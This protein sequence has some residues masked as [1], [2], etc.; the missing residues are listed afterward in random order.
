MAFYTFN[1][2]GMSSGVELFRFRYF[3]KKLVLTTFTVLALSGCQTFDDVTYKYGNGIKSVIN[4]VSSAIACIGSGSL[5]CGIGAGV[6]GYINGKQEARDKIV[7]KADA[8]LI[9]KLAEVKAKEQGAM[10]NCSWYQFC[11]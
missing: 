3:M 11:D 5:V 4:G 1:V 2:V 10:V 9:K 8:R 6:K 7:A